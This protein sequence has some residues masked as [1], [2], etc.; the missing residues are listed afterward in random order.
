MFYKQVAGKWV[1]KEGVSNLAMMEPS[2][3][4]KEYHWQV[5][6]NAGGF[7]LQKFLAGAADPVDLPPADKIEDLIHQQV[8][9]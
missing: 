8:S 5:G 2:F 6:P 3:D 7:D 4:F 9:V 1:L